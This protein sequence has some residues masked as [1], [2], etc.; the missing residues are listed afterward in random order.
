MP[1]SFV[2]SPD[3]VRSV[4]ASADNPGLRRLRREL[5]RPSSP[6]R[7]DNKCAHICDQECDHRPIASARVPAE[8]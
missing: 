1:H 5:A 2:I 4:V 8:V 6:G 7:F 3:D